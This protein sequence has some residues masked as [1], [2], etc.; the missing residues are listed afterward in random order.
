MQGKIGEAQVDSFNVPY[1][2][3]TPEELKEILRQKSCRKSF[4]VVR[5]ETLSNHPG[6]QTVQTVDARATFFRA[7][8]ERIL[9]D[10][11]GTEIIDELFEE[12]KMKLAASPVF[13]NP[14]NDKSIVI[15][16]VLKRK[17]VTF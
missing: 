9:T 8:H 5:M 1:Y 16:V 11:F 2:F 14:K 13:L 4:T 6:K 12:Y 10:H 17:M 15:L 7:V 3:T